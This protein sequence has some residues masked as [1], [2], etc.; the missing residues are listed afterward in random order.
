ML[1]LKLITR[2]RIVCAEN[3]AL[4]KQVQITDISSYN[5]GAVSTYQ[6]VK[7]ARS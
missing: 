1:F 3:M 6:K 4:S 7:E 2:S 5:F